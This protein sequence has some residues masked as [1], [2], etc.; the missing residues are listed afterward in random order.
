M[1]ADFMT[2]PLQGQKFELFRSQILG[3]QDSF[4]SVRDSGHQYDGRMTETMAA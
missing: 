3:D 4:V 2:K 1:I